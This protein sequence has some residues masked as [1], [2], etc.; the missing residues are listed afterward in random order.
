MA[1]PAALE[2]GWAAVRLSGEARAGGTLGPAARFGAGGPSG[3]LDPQNALER[4]GGISQG[5]E[6]S[7]AEHLLLELAGAGSRFV[8]ERSDTPQF[9][10]RQV[11]REQSR[12]DKI[13]S[14]R[15]RVENML[16]AES[17]LGSRSRAALTTNDAEELDK[18]ANARLN[19]LYWL[20]SAVFAQYCDRLKGAAPAQARAA[21]VAGRR[22]SDTGRAKFGAAAAALAG[23][24][25][26]WRRALGEKLASVAR[27]VVRLPTAGLL[28]LAAGVTR[29]SAWAL[30][31]IS[32]AMWSVIGAALWVARLPVVAWRRLVVGVVSALAAVSRAIDAA[33]RPQ[34][35]PSPE[36]SIWLP[37]F[38]RKLPER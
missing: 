24:A 18:L 29:A 35:V 36:V 8:E 5:V 3:G 27:S 6:F 38:G 16:A 23:R 26:G 13:A 1:Q 33:F 37:L 14:A 4:V 10:L 34:G 9:L 19:A 17:I 2:R 25:S 12:A 32:A 7:A 21:G 11:P 20:D 30:D 28:A 31:K 15:Q 22:G